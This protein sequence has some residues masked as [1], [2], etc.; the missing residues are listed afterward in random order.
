MSANKQENI[1]GIT[2]YFR[3]QIKSGDIT[4]NS[5]YNVISYLSAFML[6]YNNE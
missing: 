1:K 4:N 2:Y 3:I 5:S 6:K